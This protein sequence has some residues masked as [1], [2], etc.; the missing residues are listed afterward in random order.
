MK[1]V[2]TMKH[3]FKLVGKTGIAMGSEEPCIYFDGQHAI[4]ANA[5][6]SVSIDFPLALETPVLVSI[7]D[8]KSAQMI[9][10]D[11]HFHQTEQG[12]RINGVKADTL[13]LDEMPPD[14]T[15]I[16][17]LDKSVWRPIVRV[18]RLDGGRLRQLVGAMG[19]ADVR[20]YLNGLYMDFATGAL[21]SLD[22]HRL[23]IVE[24]AI[25]VTELPPGGLAGVIL[26]SAIAEMLASVAGVQDVFVMEKAGEPNEEGA[27]VRKRV[28][29]IA[30]ANAKFRIREIE[31]ETYPNYR[32][33]FERNKAMPVGI[34]LDGRTAQDL[35][36]I[37]KIA[38]ASTKMPLVEFQ[39]EGRTM[40]VSH[41]DKVT[42]EYPIGVRMQNPFLATVKAGYL[43]DAIEGAGHFGSAVTL[44][45]AAKD[46]GL[47]V[48]V[49]AQDFHAIVMTVRAEEDP[50]K[51]AQTSA[52]EDAP[53]T[54]A[55]HP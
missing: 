42:R 6:A 30:A 9:S 14:T 51:E 49:G 17:D 18:F 35:L 25:P 20:Y 1:P 24:D 38:S 27:V 41:L 7:K 54:E 10:P 8:L 11:L 29:C 52:K 39:G 33:A 50:D 37:C 46:E 16:L 48:Y 47:A 3:L 32:E 26:P 19:V 36:S 31:S 40:H 28:I 45:F 4:G 13:P 15:E 12:L 22:G 44:R 34:V 43:S 21:A 2:V 23:H 55:A 53:A 5:G